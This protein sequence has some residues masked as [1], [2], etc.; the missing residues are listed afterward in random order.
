MALLGVPQLPETYTAVITS[1]T[2]GTS[3][4]VPHGTAHLKKFYDY[5]NSRLR[6]D[7]LDDGSTKVYRYD[8]LVDPPFPPGR[9]DPTFPTP[10]GYQF[11]LSNPNNTCCWLWLMDPDTQVADRMSHEEMSKRA[12]DVGTDEFGE[13]WSTVLKFPFNQTDDIWLVNGTIPVPTKEDSYVDI[14]P[15]FGP[16]SGTIITNGTFQNVSLDLIDESVY[17]VP[18]ATPTFGKCKEFGH[19]MECSMEAGVAFAAALRTHT[20]GWPAPP[21]THLRK[22][23]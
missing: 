7:D 18:D 10:K 21:R 23:A 9:T 22:K 4:A 20:A 14:P 13:H 12:V 5:P 15:A 16:Q 2:T 1:T 8:V 3:H 17:W 11:Q 19:D 6:V